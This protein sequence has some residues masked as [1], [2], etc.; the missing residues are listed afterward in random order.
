MVSLSLSMTLAAF[1]DAFLSNDVYRVVPCHYIRIL[2]PYFRLSGTSC[3]V[4]GLGIGSRRNFGHVWMPLHAAPLR[5]FVPS[6]RIGVLLRALPAAALS[7]DRG[8]GELLKPLMDWVHR[9]WSDLIWSLSLSLEHWTALTDGRHVRSC[10]PSR[11]ISG[12]HGA[13]CKVADVSF[14]MQEICIRIPGLTVITVACSGLAHEIRTLM[15]SIIQERHCNS[16]IDSIYQGTPVLSTSCLRRLLVLLHGCFLFV[17]RCLHGNVGGLLSR[18]NK[19]GGLEVQWW[20]PACANWCRLLLDA[21]CVPIGNNML[22]ALHGEA[23]IYIGLESLLVDAPQMYK[24]WSHWAAKV[25]EVPKV[26]QNGQWIPTCINQLISI[27]ITCKL[28]YLYI[29]IYLF[30][31]SLFIICRSYSIHTHRHTHIYIYNTFNYNLYLLN[32]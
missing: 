28:R 1:Y 21:F 12:P 19:C 18:Q 17:Q 23:K 8:S 22:S 30:N 6:L 26:A 5:S 10:K 7:T 9:G 4:F 31:L 11:A 3:S 2:G 16:R 14:W 25:E 24:A 15:F 29:Y 13:S 20:E 27:I 32:P